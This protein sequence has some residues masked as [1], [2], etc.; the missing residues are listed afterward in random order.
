MSRRNLY[1]GKSGQMA[2]M[3]E[4]LARGYNVAIPEV[5]IGD[6][7]FVVRDENGELSRIQVK[8][9]TAKDKKRGFTA[10]FSV[11]SRQLATLLI[12]DLYYVFTVR[13]NEQWEEFLILGRRE[14]YDHHI[15]N[16][17]GTRNKK[18]TVFPFSFSDSDVIC[19]GQSFQEY[20]NNWANWP[21]VEH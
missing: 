19:Q 20:R 18:S 16:N 9:A 15:N 11:Q 3:S 4:F 21:T 1:I 17:V 10:Q 5:D 2:V 13:R 6:D 14:L 7:I 8:A 12:P